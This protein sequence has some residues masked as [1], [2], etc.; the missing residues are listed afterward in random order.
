MAPEENANPSEAPEVTTVAPDPAPGQET[1]RTEVAPD[2]LASDGDAVVE[3]LEEE[4]PT[5]ES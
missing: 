1:E 5:N 4:A 2:Q 3:G